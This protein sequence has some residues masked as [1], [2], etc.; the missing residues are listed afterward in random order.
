MP[1]YVEV[2]TPATRVKRGRLPPEEVIGVALQ[3]AGA[4]AESHTPGIVHRDIE[5]QDVM[6]TPR[7]PVKALDS[8]VAMVS[9]EP[10]T[11]SHDPDGATARSLGLLAGV[12]ARPSGGRRTAG[13]K[14]ASRWHAQREKSA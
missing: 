9:G 13:R 1:P 5:P 10:G 8:G 7:G 12:P 6:P 14:G 3:V 4:L 2:E 11:G